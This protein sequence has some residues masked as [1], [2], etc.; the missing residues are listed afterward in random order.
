ML[1]A[2]KLHNYEIMKTLYTYVCVCGNVE[3]GR[4][5]CLL[6]CCRKAKELG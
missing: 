2:K 6:I 5:S 4:T 1:D 3:Y